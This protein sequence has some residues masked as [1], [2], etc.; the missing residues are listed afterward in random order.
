MLS[1]FQVIIGKLTN[2][3]ALYFHMQI[4]N[5]CVLSINFP[6]ASLSIENI[7]CG[8]SFTLL[9]SSSS[10]APGSMLSLRTEDIPSSW[11][12]I[13]SSWS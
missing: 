6:A 13:L 1:H 4:P 9:T 10:S 3:F 12:D 5:T 11:V 8:Q 7:A 2:L